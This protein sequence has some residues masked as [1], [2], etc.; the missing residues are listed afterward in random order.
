MDITAMQPLELAL[1]ELTVRIDREGGAGVRL[2][3]CVALLFDAHMA[4]ADHIEEQMT[5]Q[6]GV[7]T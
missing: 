7:L 2:T 3:D 6:P 4:L 5:K 1:Y